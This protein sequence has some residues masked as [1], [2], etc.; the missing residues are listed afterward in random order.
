M[1]LA[2]D[3]APFLGLQVLPHQGE[4]ELSGEQLVI[5][6]PL[7]GSGARGDV[8]CLLRLVDAGE[9]AREVGP[10]AG[11]EPG[12]LLPLDEVGHA[13]ERLPGGLDE[14]LAGE[15]GGERIDGLQHRQFGA[16]FRRDD[17][18]RMRHLRA[19]VVGLDAA[20]DRAHGADG[21]L[22]LDEAALGMEEDE[23][24][25]AGLVL[26]QD[27]VGRPRIAARRG[28]VLEDAHLERGDGPGH[29]CCDRRRGPA[30]DDASR[31][32]PQ[33][34]DHARFGDAGR[35]AQS[36]LQQQLHARADAGEAFRVGKQRDQRGGTHEG[37][38]FH[39]RTGGQ[40]RPRRRGAAIPAGSDGR[41]AAA[42]GP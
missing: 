15:P 18:V 16:G 27:L 31:H 13:L 10:A 38:S 20:A 2:A 8:G 33:N 23:V 19:V 34:V 21:K 32:V 11:G 28:A 4:R 6:E 41:K 24:D 22:A 40:G 9:G 36:L 30:V 26:A 17:V 42:L 14:D 39:R 35:Q 1:P 37:L 3:C 5:G 12:R 7:P 29:G 25:L